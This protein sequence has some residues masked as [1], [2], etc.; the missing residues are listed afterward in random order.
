MKR[1]FYLL[2]CLLFLSV[3]A[4]AESVYPMTFSGD[5]TDIVSDVATSGD[6]PLRVTY[7]QE[8][9]GDFVV[10]A[11]NGNDQQELF[12]VR[13][14]VSAQAVIGAT[15]FDLIVESE[16]P[17]T[18]TI[19]P[20]KDGGDLSL[21]GSDSFVS[22]IYQVSAPTI[23]EMQAE[24]LDYAGFSVKV[25]SFDGDRINQDYLL[26]ESEPSGTKTYKKVLKFSEETRF[27]LVVQAQGVNWSISAI[28]K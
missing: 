8:S 24:Y 1:V 4:L 18:V 15:T 26:A 20:L 3:P 5:G 19:E 28:A 27:F 13:N 17:W 2:L 25:Y 7:T 22:D 12:S 16:S 6:I 10:T 23:L 21:T 9:K 14:G 11:M